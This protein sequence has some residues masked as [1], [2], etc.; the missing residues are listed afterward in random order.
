MKKSKGLGKGLSAL[1]SEKNTDTPS[2]YSSN[3]EQLDVSRNKL[4]VDSIMAGK[5]QP[6][7][8]FSEEEL[9]DLSESIKRKGVVQPIIVR[10]GEK[11]GTYEI[12]AGERRWRATKMAGLKTIPVIIM[13]LDDK[14]ALEIAL[15]ENI[16]RQNL[17]VLEEAE[18]Y[19]KLINEF[20]YTQEEL[21]EVIGKSRSQIA[22]TLRLLSLPDEVKELLNK[23]K[24]S[25]GHAR[26]LLTAPNP[27][28]LAKVIIKRDLNVR[29]TEKIV[30]RLTS[31]SDELEKQ[32]KNPKDPE[33]VALEKDLS[34]NLGLDIKITNKNEK[35]Q[36]IISYHSLAELDSI[37]RRLERKH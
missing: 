14:E 10:K 31:T 34:Y 25:S 3:V 18:G 4:P 11:Q 9:Q 35:G 29:Q 24:L 28:A 26:A 8:Y 21:S 19:Q 33:I 5:F 37:L 36:I 23:N 30:R 16:Q 17:M 22:N 15:V 32:K 20:G 2:S 6:R 27:E 7:T 13:D 12:I 1:I